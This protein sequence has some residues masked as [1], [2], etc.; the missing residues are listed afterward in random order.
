M[1][2]YNIK[3][4]DFLVFDTEGHDYEIL[5]NYD[6]DLLKPKYIQFEYI[7]M[8][9]FNTWKRNYKNLCNYL[10]ENGYK[11]I[12]TSQMDCLYELVN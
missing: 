2:Q 6:F 9:G 1:K 7:H 3:N 10:E 11:Q 5:M 12:E 4:L 8:D